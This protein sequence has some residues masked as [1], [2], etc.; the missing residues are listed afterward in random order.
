MGMELLKNVYIPLRSAGLYACCLLFV[1]GSACATPRS[2]QVFKILAF[3][4]SLTAGFHLPREAAFPAHLE[5]WFRAQGIPVEVVNGGVSGETTADGVKR[6]PK[7]LVVRP[8]IVILE[9]GTN[10]ALRGV[11][12]SITR[13]NLQAM[14]G[15]IQAKGAKVLLAGTLAPPTWGHGYQR[16]F[17]KIFPELAR[18]Y[19]VPLYPFFLQGVV[20]H[21]ELN[22]PDGLHP[23]ERGVMAIVSYLG[24]IIY[25]LYFAEDAQSDK[26]YEGPVQG[27]Y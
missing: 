7:A 1:A 6:L 13:A 9:L 19:Q 2:Q 17:D 25:R 8:D 18:T 27:I 20:R 21:P 22:L 14:I 4:D 15:M 3:G 5:K 26:A 11:D 23:N 16:A 24:P 10:D 12:P